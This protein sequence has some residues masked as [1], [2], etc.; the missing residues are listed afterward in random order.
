MI[1][2]EQLAF[3][4][5]KIGGSQCAAALGVSPWQ[6]PVSLYHEIVGNIEREDIGEIGLIGNLMEAPIRAVY[7]RR[8]GLKI[9]EKP[10]TAIHPKYPW[11]ISHFDGEVEADGRLV[12]IKCVGP[13]VSHH[14]QEDGDPE[15]VP[16]YVLAQCV[17]EANLA[18]RD[19]IDVVALLGGNDLRIY[20]VEITQDAKDAVETG[21]VEFWENHIIPGVQPEVTGADV[22]LLK[23]LY[24]KADNAK[25]IEVSGKLTAEYFDHYRKVKS[26]IKK[27]REVES[28]YKAAI[29]DYMKDCA[30]LMRSGDIEF[31]WKKSKDRTVTDWQ[32]VAKRMERVMCKFHPKATKIMSA[33]EK[34]NTET[35]TGSRS[36][37]DKAR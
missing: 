4:K 6:T 32:K 13:Y 22:E 23:K 24:W 20:P 29:Q 15:G 34:A 10:E 9:K 19:R 35:V 37:L 3:K 8:T 27:L 17:H 14:W 12:E 26:D 18:G 1:T 31:T 11:M 30:I 21:L 36:F 33:I 7:E 5:G 28:A 2:K 16:R 25:E